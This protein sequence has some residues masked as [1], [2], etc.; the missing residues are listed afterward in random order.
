MLNKM[1]KQ[2][3]GHARHLED[4]SSSKVHPFQFEVHGANPF[5]GGQ[6][7]IAGSPNDLI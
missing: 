5:P 4:A 2:H 1:K 7:M 6:S 3:Y